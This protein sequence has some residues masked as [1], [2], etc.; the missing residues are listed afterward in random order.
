MLSAS[1]EKAFIENLYRL[2]S[3]ADGQKLEEVSPN[4]PLK[5]AM[6]QSFVHFQEDIDMLKKEHPLFYQKLALTS[7]EEARLNEIEEHLI[8]ADWLLLKELKKRV[9]TLIDQETSNQQ[10]V[11][12]EIKKHKTKRLN[13]RDGWHSV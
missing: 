1:T 10:L 7:E 4:T 5:G 12:Q 11:A 2:A 9:D 13:T 8:Y 6:R 3:V